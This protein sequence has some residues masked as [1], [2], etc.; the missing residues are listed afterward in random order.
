MKFTNSRK[1]N[2]KLTYKC[3]PNNHKDIYI[4]IYINDF[5][6]FS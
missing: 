2:N 5:I 6:I 3:I 4:Y 1:I